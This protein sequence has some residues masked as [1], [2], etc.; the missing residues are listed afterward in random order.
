MVMDVPAIKDIQVMREHFAGLATDPS[1]LAAADWD[2][3]ACPGGVAP[4][5]PLSGLMEVLTWPQVY[6]AIQLMKPGTAP[7]EDSIPP[8]FFK[9]LMSPEAGDTGAPG[10]VPQTPMG[11]ALFQLLVSVWESGVIPESW[12]SSVVVSSG[13]RRAAMCTTSG[14]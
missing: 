5:P 4:R 7:G 13:L 14:T 11:R 6:A 8:E 9:L 10:E 3:V 12:Q 1:P 2:R